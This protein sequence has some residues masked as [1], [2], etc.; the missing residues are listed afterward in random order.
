MGN[1]EQCLCI[2]FKF[3]HVFGGFFHVVVCR[4]GAH[5]FRL[6]SDIPL[7]L[8]MLVENGHIFFD[9]LVT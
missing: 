9:S 5:L 7:D 2:G 6:F 1:V 3:R 8:D 4:V